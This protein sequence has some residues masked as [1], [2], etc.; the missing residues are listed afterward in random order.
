MNSNSGRPVLGGARRRAIAEPASALVRWSRLF[1]QE[2]DFPTLCEPAV[3]GV[4]L[5]AWAEANSADIHQRLLD[6][7]AILF[8]GFAVASAQD[9]ND[10]IDAVSGGALE[11]KFRASPRT[12][13]HK[14]L[15]VYTSTDYPA[16]E[17]IFPHNEHS[18]SPV[19]PL[20][21]FL[22]CDLPSLTGGETP[23]GSTRTVLAGLRPDVRE[24][25]ARR[26]I[27]YVRNYGEGFGL[28]WQTVF[29]TTDRAAVEAYCATVGIQPEWKADGGLRTRQVGA[30]LMR[31]PK[32]GE[33]V[34]FNHATF[35]HELT[36]PAS[37][38]EQLRAEFAPE[39][40][41]QNTFYGDGAPI[42]PETVRHL[43]GLYLDAMV[44]FPWQKGDV[45]MVDNMLALHGRGP[46][47]GPR[48]VMVAM[49]HACRG[50]DLDAGEAA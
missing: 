20:H 45:L 3:P 36:L 48:R 21:L 12:Q 49:A 18:Y 37:A 15:N 33:T 40:L 29:Q 6:T 4:S 13:I 30:A 10:C 23:I 43:Q 1:E 17:S 44:K 5:P 46:F 28:P 26:R 27:M 31:H 35:F 47:T 19:F 41:P 42:E 8:R 50:A 22:Y 25:F 14:D 2:G 39:D 7:G 16:Q 24:A 11:Y 9:F 32:T 38:R 34:W